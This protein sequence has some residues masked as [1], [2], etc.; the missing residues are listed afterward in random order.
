MVT[1]SYL[2]F[3]SF[4]FIIG[5]FHRK[6]FCV[7][8]NSITLQKMISVEKEHLRRVWFWAWNL[9][10]EVF[11]ECLIVNVSERILLAT[12][13][14]EAFQR[15]PVCVHEDV[16]VAIVWTHKGRGSWTKF[17]SAQQQIVRMGPKCLRFCVSIFCIPHTC[18]RMIGLNLTIL[19]P[20]IWFDS[21]L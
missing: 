13:T 16:V 17:P 10:S 15:M 2:F 20:N 12:S 14:L 9:P 3:Y 8:L 21:I 7:V 6:W 18:P 11:T 5:K 1:T 19:L 4:T